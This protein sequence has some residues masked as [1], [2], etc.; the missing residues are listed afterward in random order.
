[1]SIVRNVRKKM[2]GQVVKVSGEKT[3]AIS[4]E[5]VGRHLKYDKVVRIT[6]TILVHDETELSGVGDTVEIVE[7]RPISKRKSWRV[8]S[9]VKK[10]V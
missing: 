2:S 1:M 8:L 10:K 9:V 3:R 5:S 6:R 7:M 4:V